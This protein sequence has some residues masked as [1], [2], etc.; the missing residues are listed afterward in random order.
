MALRPL[1]GD[2]GTSPRM[3]LFYF[4]SKERLLAEAM[5]VVQERREPPAGVAALGPDE[6]LTDWARRVWREGTV[7]E[8]DGFLRLY[9][10]VYAAALRDPAAH[11]EVLD[12][13]VGQW[14]ELLVPALQTRG[15]PPERATALVTRMVAMNHGLVVDLLATGDRE[16]VEAAYEAFMAGVEAEIGG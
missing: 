12:R 13:V 2:L 5:A 6:S 9:F 14:L 10:E 7:P 4:G 8:A 16:R 3:L 15:M 11:R 1:A